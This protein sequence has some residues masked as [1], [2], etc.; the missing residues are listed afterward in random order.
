MPAFRIEKFTPH[1]THI[2]TKS[3]NF[4][5]GAATQTAARN[6]PG[7]TDNISI[8][9]KRFVISLLALLA[10]GTA[11]AD[12]Q[13]ILA[14]AGFSTM[15]DNREYSGNRF[16]IS[17]TM[18]SARLT[19]RVG[20]EWNERNRVVAAVDL[21]QNFGDNERFLTRARPLMYYRFNSRNVTAAAGIFDRS[22]L[23]EDAY[24]LAMI[25][26][27]VRYY[28][29]RVQGFMGR[30]TSSLRGDTYVEL[31]LDWCGMLG[32]TSRERFR[33]LSAGRYT[34][35]WF[36]FG[37][38]LQLYH[39]AMTMNGG[40]VSDNTMVYPY[41]GARFDAYF[42]FDVELG[43]L[44]APQRIR[45][46]GKGWE[47]PAG[48]QL[49]LRMSR[50]GVFLE[51]TLYCGDSLM[52]HINQFEEG[53]FYC[54]ERFWSTTKGIYNRT[55]IGYSRKFFDGTL[56]VGAGLRLHYDGVGM[57]TSQQIRVRVDLEKVFRKKQ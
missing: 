20:I 2:I 15:F 37:Y 12:A 28:D 30:Y 38:A 33:I 9:M 1:L 42:D 36:R 6:G 54:G 8:R 7:P 48:G 47:M 23:S 35:G 34:A 27:S 14:G 17:Q 25:G 13:Q 29:N 5:S 21:L 53:D 26:D 10:A 31:S 22:E 3:Y 32:P 19:P 52:P 55:E 50:W 45:S 46:S 40:G 57:G 39:Y 4:A 18:F 24:P 16:D 44:V 11:A 41:V 49:K 43:A 56:E 51:N